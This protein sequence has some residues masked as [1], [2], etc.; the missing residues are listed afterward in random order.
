[1]RRPFRPLLILAA[2]LLALTPVVGLARTAGADDPTSSTN[3]TS[4][5]VATGWWWY[6][7]VTPA[8]I[9]SYLS[10]NHARL[11]QLK[12]EDPTADTFSVVMVAN[13]GAFASG[14][15][16]YYGQTAADVT[17]TLTTNSARLISVDPYVVSGTTYFAV[18]EVPN[19]GSQDRAWQWW[20]GETAAGVISQVSSGSWRLI[21]LEPYVIGS[22]TYYA[23]IMVSNT[24]YDSKAWY[25]DISQSIAVINGQVAQGYRVT[26]VQVDPGGGFDAI[27]VA[28]E[29]EAW[30]FWYGQQPSNIGS[31][32]A[33]HHTRLID[34]D[35]YLSGS[36]RYW[37]SVEIDNTD[38]EQAPVNA[39]STKVDKYAATNGWG[40]GVHGEYFAQITSKGLGSPIIA[41][42]S[43]YRFEPASSIKI[44]Y[45][46]YAML[47]VEHGTLSLK[48]KITYYKDPSDPTNP[49]VC[50]STAW[51]V[52]ANAV[53]IPLST[54]LSQ[55]L[56]VSDNRI[57]RA[58]AVKF[59][60][61]KVNAWAHSIGLKSTQINQPFIGCGFQGDVRNNFTLANAAAV[62]AGIYNSRLLKGSTRTD[63]LSYLLGGTPSSGSEWG[64][65]VTSV[66][67][68]EG[69]SKFVK[70]FLADM[71]THDKGGSYAICD[72]TCG[73]YHI[74]LTDAGLVVIPFKEKG[75]VVEVGY[76]YGGFVNDMSVPCTPGSGCPV[77]NGAWNML[78]TVGAQ[79]AAL[80]IG[81]ALKTW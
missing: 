59:G 48:S 38:A 36:T 76:A 37:T 64:Q 57:T 10:T 43:T 60:V 63:L 72:A 19:T 33:A 53:T 11:T 39:A 16:W 20:Y 42:N 62:Y 5:H 29:G 9:S 69:K 47:D 22:T 70:A 54:A 52:P 17:T 74:D 18:V 1:M 68:S 61:A 35:S 79:D 15:W 41:A 81:A 58:F 67:A 75:K 23:I 80:T 32:I 3:D 40:A 45:A 50:P 73:T 51:D 14:Y 66:A 65:I 25:Y 13:S 6:T 44:L 77:E 7:G 12:V 71:T 2:A 56:H 31:N 26:H 55:M 78:G 28:G 4:V 8:Q 30:Y 21:A 27:L 34:I 49:G 46:T 24:G